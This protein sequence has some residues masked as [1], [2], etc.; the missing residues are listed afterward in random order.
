MYDAHLT[1]FNGDQLHA[2]AYRLTV[3]F[4]LL[5]T[6]DAPL[7]INIASKMRTK[8]RAAQQLA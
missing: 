3:C 2:L 5:L 6:M 7:Q 1:V 4:C 8:V